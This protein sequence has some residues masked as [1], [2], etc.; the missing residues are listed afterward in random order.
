[1]SYKTTWVLKLFPLESQ[2][3]ND[4]SLTVDSHIVITAMD[5][6]TE[7]LKIDLKCLTQCML[8]GSIGDSGQHGHGGWKIE[9]W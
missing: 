7:N 6:W 8:A 4:K 3:V 9:V 2:T 5:I 1:M